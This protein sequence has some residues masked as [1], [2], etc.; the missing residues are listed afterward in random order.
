MLLFIKH[1]MY[2]GFFDNLLINWT[3]L[4]RNWKF[5]TVKK[6]GPLTL[7][8]HD[9]PSVYLYFWDGILSPVSFSLKRRPW[10][11]QR[12]VQ[13]AIIINKN[14]HPQLRLR[15]RLNRRILVKFSSWKV[16]NASKR[17]ISHFSPAFWHKPTSSLPNDLRGHS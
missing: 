3:F 15:S 7:T 12:N 13:R 14:H 9:A 17:I 16:R 10:K 5:R 11:I 2:T 4:L 6:G 1:I 8:S